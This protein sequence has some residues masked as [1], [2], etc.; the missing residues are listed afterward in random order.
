[1]LSTVSWLGGK[2]DFLGVA[3]MVVGCI[4]VLLGA[5][6]LGITQRNPRP[7]GDTSFLSWNK[8]ED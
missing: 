1:M 4:C 7:L 5:L 2:N 8:K 6:F 3:F